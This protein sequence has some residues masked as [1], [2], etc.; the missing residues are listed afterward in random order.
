[1]VTQLGMTDLGLMQYVASEGEK[2]PYRVEYSEK[3]AQ[4]IDSKI[5]AILQERYEFAKK[6]IKE[7]QH[8]L[9]L[10]VE[11]L[12]ILETINRTQILYIHENKKLPTEVVAR[13]HYLIDTNQLDERYLFD[14][15]RKE[16]LPT[17]NHE[18]TNDHHD[19]DEHHDDENNDNKNNNENQPK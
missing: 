8:E 16:F 2:N 7:N 4:L 3:S 10:I 9:Q 1:M 15:E 14:E 11:S 6:T 13:I 19:D 17:S 12:L 18:S 5:E